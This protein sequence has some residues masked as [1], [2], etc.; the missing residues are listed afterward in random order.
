MHSNVELRE[1]G[2]TRSEALT[3][4]ME[5]YLEAIFYIVAEKGAARAK[6]ISKRLKVNHSSVTGAPGPCEQESRPLRAV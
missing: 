1:P 5:D 2:M 3:A 4:S 6:D